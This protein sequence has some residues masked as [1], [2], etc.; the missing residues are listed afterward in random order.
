QGYGLLPPSSSKAPDFSCLL[1]QAISWSV[2]SAFQGGMAVPGTPSRIMA[3]MAASGSGSISEGRS[4]GPR[5][6]LNVKPWQEPQSCMTKFFSSASVL[7]SAENASAGINTSTARTPEYLNALRPER[8]IP[9][10]PEPVL[11][12]CGA[13]ETRTLIL[14][15]FPVGIQ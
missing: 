15:K 14:L 10:S 2:S 5:P 6:P 12:C 3:S 7:G 4:G 8:F 9:T 1:I 13:E 11:P